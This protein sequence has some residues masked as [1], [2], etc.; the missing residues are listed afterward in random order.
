MKRMG[1]DIAA[2]MLRIENDMIANGGFD[3]GPLYT[4]PE[5]LDLGVKIVRQER[6][7]SHVYDLYGA[8][9]DCERGL[10]ILRGRLKQIERKRKRREAAARG[11][12]A[13][14]RVN[15]GDDD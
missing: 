15:W 14:R 1:L 3:P 8:C 12:P 9:E 10:A 4:C 5:C 2:T 13:N 7:G 6:R 11:N